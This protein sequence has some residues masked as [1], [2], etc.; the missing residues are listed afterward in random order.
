MPPGIGGGFP[1]PG[2][3]HDDNRMGGVFPGQSGRPSV[4]PPGPDETTN[5]P[6]S[7]PDQSKFDQFK[8]QTEA[9]PAKPETPHVRMLPIL[10]AVVV[11]A[12]LLLGAV[13]G[14]VWLVAGGGDD[15]ALSVATGD[16]VKRDG[17]AAVK[18]ECS[19]ATSFEVVSI[20][21]DKGKCAD[22]QQPYV[23]NPTSDGK[24]QVLCLK[25]KA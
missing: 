24:S 2:G 18:A 22:P 23:V 15:K 19:D 9:T 5:W 20:V 16:C 10:L 6:N 1:P 4:T 13:F 12:L 14:I 7:G 17:D 3:P 21:D 11:G 8:Q 25:P